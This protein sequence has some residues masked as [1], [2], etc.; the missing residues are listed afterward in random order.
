[1]LDFILRFLCITSKT[2]VVCSGGVLSNFCI[3][4]CNLISKTALTRRLQRKLFQM[5]EYSFLFVRMIV[6]SLP[7]GLFYQVLF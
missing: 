4:K 5:T 2:I 3:Q 7:W 6:A 1:M